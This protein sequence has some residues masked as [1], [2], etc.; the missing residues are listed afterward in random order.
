MQSAAETRGHNRAMSIRSARNAF[1]STG[2]HATIA[3][4]VFYSSSGIQMDGTCATAPVRPHLCG[5]LCG[6]CASSPVRASASALVNDHFSVRVTTSF[7]PQ[8]PAMRCN[9][10]SVGFLPP[11]LSRRLS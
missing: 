4:C 10:L 7:R 6:T 9:V 2:I 5:H 1:A 11:E 3:T 8:A